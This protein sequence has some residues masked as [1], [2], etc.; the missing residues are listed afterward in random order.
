LST[1]PTNLNKLKLIRQSLGV[2][3]VSLSKQSGVSKN[4]IINIEAGRVSPKEKTIVRL[5]TTLGVELYSL[6]PRK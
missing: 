5:A 6:G 2:S 4:T 3:Q 1:G